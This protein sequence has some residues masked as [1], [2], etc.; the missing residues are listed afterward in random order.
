MLCR[1]A[2][3]G[4]IFFPWKSYFTAKIYNV[5]ECRELKVS[6]CVRF[7]INFL[8]RGKY[9]MELLHRG[10]DCIRNIITRQI[11]K[12]LLSSNFQSSITGFIHA[13]FQGLTLAWLVNSRNWHKDQVF[14]SWQA[15]QDMRRLATVFTF[16]KLKQGWCSAKISRTLQGFQCEDKK[17][18]L[19]DSFFSPWFYDR[20]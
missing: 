1:Y 10:E 14:Q 4:S 5:A 6:Q 2:Q 18:G 16:N 3:I 9:L 12:L 11:L 13:M 8:H 20:A 19:N 7:S 17:S 15:F